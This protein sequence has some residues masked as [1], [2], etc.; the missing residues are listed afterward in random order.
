MQHSSWEM[1]QRG[2]FVMFS[3][4]YTQNITENGERT[5]KLN[6]IVCIHPQ[7]DWSW[8]ADVHDNVQHKKDISCAYLASWHCQMYVKIE[9][10]IKDTLKDLAIPTSAFFLLCLFL[11]D[12]IPKIQPHIFLLWLPLVTR[13]RIETFSTFLKRSNLLSWS[14]LSSSR[15]PQIKAPERVLCHP[16]MTVTCRR[17]AQKHDAER[18]TRQ[19]SHH[20]HQN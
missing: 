18:L 16:V 8:P 6:G 10:K 11:A 5:E 14:G 17:F 15:R 19:A 1:P 12:E 13:E 2:I 7:L 4:I 3:L 9:T 20:D